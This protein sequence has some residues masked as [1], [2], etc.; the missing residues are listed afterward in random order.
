MLS[1]NQDQFRRWESSE[2][3]A[4]VIDVKFNDPESMIN[5]NKVC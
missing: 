2:A 5:T 3:I 4:K 1:V